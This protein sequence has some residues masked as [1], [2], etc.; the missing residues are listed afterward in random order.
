MKTRL[1]SALIAIIVVVPI[2]LIGGFIFNITVLILS[3]LGLKEF[4]DIKDAKKPIPEIIKL[5]SYIAVILLIVSNFDNQNLIFLID[6]RVLSGIFM[7]FLLSTVLYH[8]KN[9]YS[10]EDAF[11]LIGGVFFLGISLSLFITIRT[12]SINLLVYL[13]LITIVTDTYAYITGFLI[14]KHKLLEIISPKKTVE[15]LIGGTIMGTFISTC[16]YITIVSDNN[17][18]LVILISAFLSIAGQFGDLFFSA[19]KRYFNKKDFSNIMPGH[20]G[21]L[22]RLD[23]A[24]F[25]LLGFMFFI[26]IIGG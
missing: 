17:L 13:L 19:I 25:V 24:I 6:Y 12:T 7:V 20:G 5:I 11:Y 21:I 9:T 14:G 2:I 16:F 18:L 10:I 23:S 8:N 4:I 15:G 22:D 1:I 26:N 3:L